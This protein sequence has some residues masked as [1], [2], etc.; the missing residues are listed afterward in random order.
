MFS[1][2][3]WRRVALLG[4]AQWQVRLQYPANLGNQKQAKVL[5][6]NVKTAGDWVKVKRLEKNLTPGHVAAKMG[7]AT[8]LVGAWENSTQQP[9]NQQLKVLASVLDFDT[10]GFETVVIKPKNMP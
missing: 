7:I 4:I 2:S 3:S 1:L 10:N 5:K 9:E 8:S 6:L